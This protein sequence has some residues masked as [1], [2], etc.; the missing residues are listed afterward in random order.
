M[1]EDFMKSLNVPILISIFATCLA[2]LAF[3]VKSFAQ[4]SPESPPSPTEEPLEIPKKACNALASKSAFTVDTDI[5]YDNI[6][7][8]DAK[9]QYSA[10]QQLTVKRP[11][12]LKSDY[13]GDERNTLLIY[14]GKTFSILAKKLNLYAT[15]PAPA[16]IDPAIERIKQK[17]TITIPL[18]DLL[19]TDR[20]D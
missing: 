10:F 1:K 12:Q 5:N 15:G 2:T 20:K 6:L 16:S 7:G 9:V 14:D 13:L 11:N 19:V 3:P 18:S 17:Y 8:S 4:V